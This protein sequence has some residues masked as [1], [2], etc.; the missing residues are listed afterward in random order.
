MEIDTK[1]KV[2]ARLH[3]DLNGTGLNIYNPY[4]QDQGINAVYLLFKSEKPDPLVEGL[5][6]LQISGAIT[7]GFEHD[8]VLPGLVDETTEAVKL[9]QRVGII[10]N[11]NGVLKA[12]Y[13]GGE[14]LLSAVQ[15]K[16]DTTGKRIVI[17]GA[18]TVAKTLVLALQKTSQSPKE[19]HIFNRTLENA[20]AIKDRFES[21][22]AINT[23]ENLSN[24][25]GDILIN[26]SRIGSKVE[27][28]FYTSELINRFAVVADVT[29]GVESTN[30]TSIAKE[31]NKTVISGWDM[32]THQAAVVLREILGHDA[33]IDRLRHFVKEG[34]STTNHGVVIKKK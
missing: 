4:F 2:I 5:C 10:I 7:A 21:V 22:T 16:I 25:E 29:F 3:T 13:Q 32:F 27:D 15:E 8:P 6:N 31:A 12:H 33:N 20:G 34:L 18:G 28:S 17:V 1:T 24:A 26:A 23:I 14:G 30:L 9:A 19:I 11:T